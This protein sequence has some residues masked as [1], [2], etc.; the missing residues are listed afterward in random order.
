[1][2]ATNWY[3][4]LLC[5]ADGTLYTG[6]TTD[7]VRRIRQ[8]NGELSGGA[9]YTAYR[10]PVMLCWCEP[11]ASRSEAQQREAAIKTLNRTQKEALYADH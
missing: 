10:R 6:V 4:Y 9:K 11:A 5:C 1:M 8:H 7:L 2:T 3:V